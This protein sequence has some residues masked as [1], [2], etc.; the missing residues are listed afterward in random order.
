MKKFISWY[1]IFAGFTAQAQ[2][3]RAYADL[4]SLG[5]E[6]QLSDSLHI[7]AESL[8]KKLIDSNVV[9]K[10]FSPLLG[11]GNNSRLKNRNYYLAGKITS[12]EIF[13]LLVLMEKKKKT[14]SASVQVIYLVTTKKDGTYIASI[15][16]AVA[17]TKKKTSYNTSSWLYKDYRVVLDSK[18]TV[19]DKSYNDLSNYKIN[20]GGRFIL[21]PK[22][23]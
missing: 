17:G 2:N 3:G 13:N 12:N 22:Y 23:E 5:D 9:K 7:K 16:A 21:Y 8:Q 6:V 18:M 4:L 1:L 11:S 14:D 20:K 15:E 19:N 10:W